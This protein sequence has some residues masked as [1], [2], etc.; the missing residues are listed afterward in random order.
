MFGSNLKEEIFLLTVNY[1][2]RTFC[3]DNFVDRTF[4]WSGSKWRTLEKEYLLCV[5]FPLVCGRVYILSGFFLFLVNDRLQLVLGT[6]SFV[7]WVKFHY[8]EGLP[9]LNILFR[10][11]RFSFNDIIL[12][13]VVFTHT[14]L[15][16]RF[17]HPSIFLL[18]RTINFSPSPKVVKLTAQSRGWC[19]APKRLCKPLGDRTTNFERVNKPFGDWMLGNFC[20][21]QQG[22]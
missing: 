15:S 13:R 11:K 5:D 16:S 8:G 4:F 22:F 10:V 7:L 21:H 6:I 20:G 18:P 9:L 14:F 1:E 12:V 2:E 19:C 17:L 3:K